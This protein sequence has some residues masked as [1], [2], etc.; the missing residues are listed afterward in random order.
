MEQLKMAKIRRFQAKE[1]GKKAQ[2]KIAAA[3]F[4]LEE[5]ETIKVAWVTH[6]DIRR[7]C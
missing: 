6:Q 4:Y 3:V 7:K 1:I 2:M 5:W